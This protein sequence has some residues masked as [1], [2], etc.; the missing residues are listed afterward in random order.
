MSR[1]KKKIGEEAL[2]KAKE[3]LEKLKDGKLAVQLKAIIASGEYQVESVALIFQVSK[4][5]IFR[6]M[7]KFQKAGLNGLKDSPKGHLASKLDTEHKKEIERWILSG[8]TSDGK[9]VNW[10]LN[11]LKAE[12]ERVMDVKISTTALW[13][14]LKGMSF[15]LKKPRPTH[16]KADKQKQND[17]KK[18]S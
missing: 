2:L 5:S 18:N 8:R 9:K 1:P 6:W 15:V 11:K 10:T 7:D 14:Y 12:V 13:N 17:F 3:E 4:R 16:V